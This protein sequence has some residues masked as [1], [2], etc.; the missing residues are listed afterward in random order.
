M[1]W[2]TILVGI[3]KSGEAV[4]STD[5]ISKHECSTASQIAKVKVYGI[6][7]ILRPVAQ[8]IKNDARVHAVPVECL[9]SQ[10]RLGDHRRRKSAGT[11]AACQGTD[12]STNASISEQ[13]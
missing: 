8:G 3:Q 12:R 13:K 5:N 2:W 6:V 11:L 7:V 4:S 9:Q 1:Y 10:K